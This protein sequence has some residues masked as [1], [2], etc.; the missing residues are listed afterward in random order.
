MQTTMTTVHLI[1]IP[2]Q[3]IKLTKFNL[4]TY[5]TPK[6]LYL[7]NKSRWSTTFHRTF[8]PNFPFSKH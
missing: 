5:L 6:N 4:L 1:T 8:K 3:A 2:K 7:M